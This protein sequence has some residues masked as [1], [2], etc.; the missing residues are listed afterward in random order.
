MHRI[1]EAL[2]KNTLNRLV[3]DV[4]ELHHTIEKLCAPATALWPVVHCELDQTRVRLL[5]LMQRGPLGGDGLDDEVARFLGAAK[6][7]GQRTALFI[8]DPT[9]HILLRAAPIVITGSV[10]ATGETTT[11]KLPD[12]HRRFTVQT[13]AFDMAC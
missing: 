9:R 6:G 5:L 3:D 11:G 4:S 12:F 13:Q 10:V 7:D 1:F 8:H 2:Y